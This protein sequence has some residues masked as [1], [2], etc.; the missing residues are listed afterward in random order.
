MPE[1]ISTVTACYLTGYAILT[2][3]GRGRNAVS[4]EAHDAQKA[5]IEVVEFAERSHALFGDKLSALS[6]LRALQNECRENNWDGNDAFALNPLAMQNAENFVRAL[7]AD[8][9]VPEF[10]PEPDGSISLD[11]IESRTQL[12]SISI[13]AGHRLAFAW[14]DGTDKGHGVATFSDQ[15]I[16]ARILDG[17]NSITNYRYAPHRAA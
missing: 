11:W 10:A 2:A 4:Q 17:I 15:Q 14:L 3:Y 13:G 8:V 7:P 16:P 12:F 9:P 6:A 1:P 5:A